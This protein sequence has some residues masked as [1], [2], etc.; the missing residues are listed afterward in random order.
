MTGKGLANQAL[1]PTGAIP[2]VSDGSGYAERMARLSWLPSL[3]ALSF[4]VP[5]VLLYWQVAGPSA[6]LAD[7]STGVHI[8]TGQWILA[9]HAIPRRDLFSFTLAGKSWCD[10]EWLGDVLF[11]GADRLHGLSGAAV[12]S[13]G[14]LCLTSVVIYRTARLHAG[15]IVA[16]A[17]CALAM[18][19][20]T[21]HWL[22]R[23]HLFT[24]LLLAVFCWVLAK[25]PAEAR[26][27]WWVLPCIMILWVNLHPGFVAGFLV[28][29]AWLAGSCL[30]WRFGSTKEA[31]ANGC[32]RATWGLVALAACA[33]ATLVNP[34]FLHLHE[35]V[36]LYLFSP[37]TV[38][39]HVEEWLSPNFH[40]ARLAWF[41][42]FLPLAGAA[43]LW[44]S[45]KRRFYWCLSL[46]GFMHLALIS[47]RNVP[48]LAIVCAA[49]LAAAAEEALGEFNSGLMV[50]EAGRLLEGM[51]SARGTAAVWVL[52]VAMIAAIGASPLTLGRGACIP[53][54]AIERLPHGRLFTTDQWADYLVYKEPGRRVFFDGRNDFYGPAFVESYLRVMKAKPGWETILVKYHVSIALVPTDGAIRAALSHDEAW[55]T[56][57]R[58]SKATMFFRRKRFNGG[59]KH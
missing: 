13:L 34:Y 35:H 58:D 19:T 4:L 6:L 10:W 20:T 14:L 24:W 30:G 17:V 3:T 9:H 12:L 44:H 27:R 36:A 31:R 57:Y 28:L 7:P 42:I 50:R 11:A 22:A 51:K 53:T 32:G 33:A 47:V 59:R 46:F 26:R 37:S 15:P 52:G 8:S 5:I 21:I 43:G 18:A 23:P 2:V 29:G 38:T 39:A 1:P 49:P 56:A 48:L 41:E 45:L 25:Q 55:M 54:K 40:N 16:G